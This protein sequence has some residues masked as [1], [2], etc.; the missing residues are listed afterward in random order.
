MD[1]WIFSASIISSPDRVFIKFYAAIF[2][3][4]KCPLKAFELSIIN[5]IFFLPEIAEVYQDLKRGS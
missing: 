3:V 1:Y 4:Y 5:T 2:I